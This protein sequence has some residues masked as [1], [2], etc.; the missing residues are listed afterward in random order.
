MTAPRA[1]SSKQP[2]VN[3][4]GSALLSLFVPMSFSA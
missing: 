3:A 4:A 2:Y 1:V